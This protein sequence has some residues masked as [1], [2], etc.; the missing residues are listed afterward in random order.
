MTLGVVGLGRIGTSVA[1]RARSFGMDLVC[2]DP[3]LA[4]GAEKAVGCGR[5]ESLTEL[6]ARADVVSFHC[7]L[8]EDTH[9]ML[10]HDIL[11]QVNGLF[12]VN[13]ARGGVVDENA[14]LTALESGKVGGAGLDVLESEPNVSPRLIEAQRKYNLLITPHASFYSN[15]AFEEMRILAAREVK[16]VLQG[17]RPHYQ[18]N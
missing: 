17:E 1:L 11:E 9:H 18:V 14:L 5:V 16:R 15:E 8:T 4:P 3:Y 12:V 13:A 7:P 2:Y 10:S 6:I